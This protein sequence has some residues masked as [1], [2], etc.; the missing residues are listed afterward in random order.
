MTSVVLQLDRFIENSF[1]AGYNEYI[2]VDRDDSE[3]KMQVMI[4][5][6]QS[7]RGYIKR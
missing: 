4:A 6:G 3:C 2:S 1:L 5:I 7:Q